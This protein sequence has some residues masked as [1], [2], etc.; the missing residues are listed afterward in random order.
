M[1]KFIKATVHIIF[2]ILCKTSHGSSEICEFYIYISL[3]LK[4]LKATSHILLI[5]TIQIS[6]LKLKISINSMVSLF[7]LKIHFF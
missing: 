1:R 2:K 6:I 5:E 7:F 4:C 3:E